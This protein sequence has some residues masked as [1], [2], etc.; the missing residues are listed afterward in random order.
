LVVSQIKPQLEAALGR[1]LAHQRGAQ[2]AAEY[3]TATFAALRPRT[4]PGRACVGRIARKAL[5]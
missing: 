2:T 5:S 1:K 4:K 3:E